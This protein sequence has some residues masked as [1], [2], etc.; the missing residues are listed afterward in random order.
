MAK[1]IR[2]TP[3][4][5]GASW[6]ISIPPKLSPTGKRQNLSYRTQALALAA[7]ADLKAK[8]EEF[9]TQA[10]AIS[11]TLSDQA[12]AAAAILKPHGLTVLEAA[13]QTA[14]ARAMLAPYGITPLQAA[15]RIAAMERETIASASIETAISAFQAAKESKSDKQIQAIKHLAAHLREDFAG[16]QLITITGKEIGEHLTDRTGG[17]SAFNAKLRLLVTFWRW[18][19][20]P[21]RGWCKADALAH[22]E[23]RETPLSA[24]GT[25]DG[26]QAARLMAT[27]EK[28]FP[29]TVVPFAIALFTGMRQAEIDRLEKK[30]ITSEGITVP[31]VNDRKNNRRRFIAIP[32]PLAAWL[33]AYPITDE[34]IPANWQRKQKAVRRLAG[35]KVWSDLV[36]TL[37]LEPQL[38][39]EPPADAPEWPA[40][41]LRHTAA[42]VA[43]AL[44]KTLETL[45]FEHGHTEGVEMLRNHYIGRMPKKEALAIWAIGP[46]GKKLPALKIA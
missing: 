13:E 12:T 26:K 14:A 8:R 33:K 3:K 46:N 6:R 34:V 1:P 11:A 45:I 2:L 43:L 40:N 22:V 36:P 41:A 5:D 29:E 9:G 24:I 4:K 35:W 32:A 28:H 30:D 18:S 16:R 10:R 25:L 17:P 39:E 7:A 44:G 42:S 27:A 31:A 15:E 20:K 21:P 23:R 38:A 19:A 37:D